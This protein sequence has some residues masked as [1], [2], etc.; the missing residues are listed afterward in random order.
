MSNEN[1]A[2]RQLVHRFIDWDLVERRL[3]KF[4]SIQRS[5]PLDTLK[6]YGEKPPYYCHY[7]AWHLGTYASDSLF[8]R[9]DELFAIAE[10]LPN[11]VNEK[12]L[13]QSPD[14]SDFWSLVWQLQ[15]AEYL[16]KIG[17]NVQWGSVTGGPDFSVD[18]ESKVHY[19]ECYVYRKSFGLMS[20]IEE[21]LQRLDSSIR[22][23]YDLYVQLSLTVKDENIK[24][25]LDSVLA[26]FTSPAYIA[27]AKSAA[28]IQHPVVLY[29]KCNQ[30]ITIYMEGQDED[31]YAPGIHGN[32]T[33]DPQIYLEVALREAF[34][35][36][37]GKNKLEQYRPNLVA[38]NLLLSQDAQSAFDRA[39]ELELTLP[40]ATQIPDDIDEIA[41]VVIGFNEWLEPSHL[42]C[43]V[44][45]VVTQSDLMQSM[46]SNY[47]Y[48]V[49]S[50]IKRSSNPYTE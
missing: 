40:L 5:F 18:I 13:L 43:C 24:S 38:V 27:N 12:P 39:D 37:K 17:S 10:K 48:C 2:Q 19:V 49:V 47:P 45:T 28:L 31:A 15:M 33:G 4:H 21:L 22:V 14:F 50:T 34:Q 25:F 8:V 36:K 11:W 26:D 1:P 32:Q 6:K 41:A 29:P 16:C 44:T 9:L 3:N 42:K 35:A 46:I 20:F 30:G 7:M 23:H